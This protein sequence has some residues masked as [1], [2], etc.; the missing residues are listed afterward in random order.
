MFGATQATMGTFMAGVQ[1]DPKA[2]LGGGAGVT[3]QSQSGGFTVPEPA[4]AGSPSPSVDQGNTV[5]GVFK[6]NG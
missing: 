1:L 6:P 3:P 5:N 4:P 2:F